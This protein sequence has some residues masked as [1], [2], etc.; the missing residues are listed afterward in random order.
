[1]SP[2]GMDVRTEACWRQEARTYPASEF[3]Y[4]GFS[5]AGVCCF[6]VSQVVKTTQ[7]RGRT[8]RTLLFAGDL[9]G[10]STASRDR[11]NAADRLDTSP[12]MSH[13]CLLRPTHHADKR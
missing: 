3:S 8:E 4:T 6:T 1:M 7:S 5:S 11:R 10:R 13:Y 12:L 9:A 2:E